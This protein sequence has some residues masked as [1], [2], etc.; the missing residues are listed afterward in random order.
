MAAFSQYLMVDDQ[1]RGRPA[2]PAL[3]GFETGLKTSKGKRKPA[4]DGF[5]LPLAVKQYGSNDVLWG[6][7][8]PATGPTEVTIQNKIGKGSWQRLTVVPTSGVYGFRA[9]HKKQAALPGEVDPPGRR[10]DHGPADPR[11][12]NGR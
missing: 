8:R 2:A 10:H 6:R 1:P 3:L 9:D 7:V 12:L 5:I 11:V 4:Y